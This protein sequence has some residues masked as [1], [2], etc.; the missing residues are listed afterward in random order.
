MCKECLILRVYYI[1]VSIILLYTL[2]SID[3]AGTDGFLAKVH[4]V[5][6]SFTSTTVQNHNHVYFNKLFVTIKKFFEG[7]KWECTR[8]SH[9]A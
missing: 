7:E 5:I 8:T 3:S 9:G 4:I 6:A 1:S 2:Y